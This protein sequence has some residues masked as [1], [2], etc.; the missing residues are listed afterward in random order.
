M[1]CV[2]VQYI[3]PKRGKQKP[4]LFYKAQ[5]LKDAEKLMVKATADFS[6]N[7]KLFIGKPCSRCHTAFAL[8]DLTQGVCA[9]CRHDMA[10]Q[11][12]PDG[13]AY[14]EHQWT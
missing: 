14:R 11:E 13:G 7:H 9:G 5:T 12:E 10:D 1:Y 6:E 2:Y 8:N 4:V 3:S